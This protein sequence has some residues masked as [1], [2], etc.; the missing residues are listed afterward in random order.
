[1]RALVSTVAVA[2]AF[3]LVTGAAS[4]QSLG[5]VAARTQKEREGKAKPAKV[6]TESDL[7]GRPSSAGSVS[8]PGSGNPGAEPV[9][10]PSPGAEGKTADGKTADGKTADGKTEATKPKTPEEERAEQVAAWREKLTKA[11]ADVTRL[12]GEVSELQSTLAN[13]SAAQYSPARSKAQSRLDAA[14]G[15][16]AAAQASVESLQEE[17]RRAGM[18]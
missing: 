2:A 15:E 13:V 16:L 12:S 18:R 10:S 8:Q 4:A 6:L 17:G 7:R 1:M 9:A 14:R 11:Q 3:V 5:E